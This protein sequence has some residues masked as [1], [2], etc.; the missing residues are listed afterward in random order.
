MEKIKKRRR[1]SLADTFFLFFFFFSSI[2]GWLKFERSEGR[3]N[4][5]T[6]AVVWRNIDGTAFNAAARSLS[7][8]VLVPYDRQLR[9]LL[10]KETR[11]NR[12]GNRKKKKKKGSKKEDTIMHDLVAA[13]SSEVEET[14]IRGSSEE[15]KRKR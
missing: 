5:E 8:G 11:G 3:E 13:I 14:R 6:S 4:F 10:G 1:V 2:E 15:A 7:K 12:K 9:G